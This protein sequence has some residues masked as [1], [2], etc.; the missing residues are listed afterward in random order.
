MPASISPNV[1]L[2][3]ASVKV[4]QTTASLL[5]NNGYKVTAA[6]NLLDAGPLAAEVLLDLIVLD[7][8][9]IAAGRTSETVIPELHQIP[10]RHDVPV[11]F[12]STHQ[13]SSI[14]RRNHSWG[15]SFH[16]SVPTAD[17]VFL[18]FVDRSLRQKIQTPNT[19]R[20]VPVLAPHIVA[21]GVVR[22]PS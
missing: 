22:L 12:T 9:V 11:L 14:I 1:L 2:I 13:R 4:L 3:D 6:A 7:R 18:D 8:S 5:Q 20:S 10:G 15:A 16:L 21:P 19:H 17:A